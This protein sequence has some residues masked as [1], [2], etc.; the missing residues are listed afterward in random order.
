M[1]ARKVEDMALHLGTENDGDEVAVKLKEWLDT[2]DQLW[3][4]ERYIMGPV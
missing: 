3:G 2:D 4:E 1:I